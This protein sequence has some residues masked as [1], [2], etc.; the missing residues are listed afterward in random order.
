[1][2]GRTLV[3]NAHMYSVLNYYT[4]THV[5]KIDQEVDYPPELTAPNYQ[6][7]SATSTTKFYNIFFTKIIQCLSFN[8]KIIVLPDNYLICLIISQ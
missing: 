8:E 7:A 2:P 4:L 3:Q 1:M 5:Q 6:D